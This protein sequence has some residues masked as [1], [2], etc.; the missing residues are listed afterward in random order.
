[1]LFC[2]IIGTLHRG[3]FRENY[4]RIESDYFE[5]KSDFRKDKG[6]LLYNSEKFLF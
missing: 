6:N 1:M 4:I 2:A 3:F 5:L